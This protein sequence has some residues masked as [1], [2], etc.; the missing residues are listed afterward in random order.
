MR[1]VNPK[2]IELTDAQIDNLIELLDMNFIK[3]I[4]EDEEVDNMD[5]IVSM[6]DVFVK[7]KKAK[8]EGK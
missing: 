2:T 3:I 8:E 4:R 5:Y 7:L 6:C 1:G